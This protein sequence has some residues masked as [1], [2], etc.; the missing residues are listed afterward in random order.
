MSDWDDCIILSLILTG[1]VLVFGTGLIWR[2]WFSIEIIRA[3]LWTGIALKL[4]GFGYL[5]L[6]FAW[7]LFALIRDF[8]P[9]RRLGTGRF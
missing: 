8:L 5:V 7:V 6:R 1:T 3:V 4:S 9:S 2:D